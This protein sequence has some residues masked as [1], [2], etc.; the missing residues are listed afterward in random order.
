MASAGRISATDD[1][2]GDDSLNSDEDVEAQ[3][4]S[5]KLAETQET[6]LAEQA[7]RRTDTESRGIPEDIDDESDS[8]GRDE[9]DG[10]PSSLQ[11]CEVWIGSSESSE[12]DSSRLDDLDEDALL[13]RDGIG[14]VYIPLAANDDEV[15]GFDPFSVSTWRRE[16]TAEESQA[17]LDVSEANFENSRVKIV[18]LLRAIWLRKKRDRE[19]R[20]FEAHFISHFH[21]NLPREFS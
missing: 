19:R 9:H 3:Q 14:I 21:R 8:H 17:L 6:A 18:R 4:A 5:R 11:S 13:K 7:D 1:S 12:S 16:L 10:V 15:P 20:E 2:Q